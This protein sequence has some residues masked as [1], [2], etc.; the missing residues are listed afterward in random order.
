MAGQVDFE[1]EGWN[2]KVESVKPNVEEDAATI[3]V[4]ELRVEVK[5]L[6]ELIQQLVKKEGN[7]A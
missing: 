5:E 3:Q 7:G 6:K 2:K 1:G 4:K